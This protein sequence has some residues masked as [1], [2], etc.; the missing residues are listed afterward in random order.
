VDPLSREAPAGLPPALKHDGVTGMSLTHS[1]GTSRSILVTGAHRSGTTWVGSILMKSPSVFGIVEPFNPEQIHPGVCVARF[2]WW[3]TRVTPANE[4]PYREGLARMLRLEFDVLDALR[5]GPRAYRL[6]VGDALNVTRARIEHRRTLLKDPIAVMSVE[7]LAETFEVEP[8]VLIRHPAAFTW[9]LKRLNWRFDF[10]NF[11]EQPALMNGDLAPFKDEFRAYARAPSD[12]VVLAALLWKAIYSV[13]ARYRREQKRWFFIRH[14]D[15]SR[16][17]VEGFRKIFDHTGLPYTPEIQREV[18]ASSMAEN[19]VE[20]K[21]GVVHALHRNSR[22]NVDVWR[23]R[24]TPDEV[25]RL[26]SRLGDV[27]NEFYTDAEWGS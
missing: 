5:A 12:I 25:E 17:P 27:S 4:G 22:A 6:A 14:E 7:W 20:P 8:V 11:L 3:F 21:P 26:R 18:I 16:E 15:L 23:T 2:P 9:S 10:R 13:V 19:P 1:S 24:L